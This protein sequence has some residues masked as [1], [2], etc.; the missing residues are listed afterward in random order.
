[1][2][3]WQAILVGA[4]PPTLLLGISPVLLGSALGYQHLVKDLEQTAGWVNGIVF[5]AAIGIVILLQSG[6]N[7]VI[8]FRKI[9]VFPKLNYLLAVNPRYLG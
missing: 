2:K 6:A 9:K 4:R 5:L 8:G 3:P 1:M 7:L